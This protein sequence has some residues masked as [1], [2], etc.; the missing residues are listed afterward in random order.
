MLGLQSVPRNAR[1]GIVYTASSNL[2]ANTL[3]VYHPWAGGGLLGGFGGAAAERQQGLR[4]E[5]NRLA[6]V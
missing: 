4:L 3:V 5:G 6:G 1:R 2:T